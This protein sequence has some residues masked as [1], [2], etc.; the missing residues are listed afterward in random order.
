MDLNNN[1]QEVYQQPWKDPDRNQF[2]VIRSIIQ[3]AEKILV[4][5]KNSFLTD[6][7]PTQSI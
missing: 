4:S 2:Q 5:L 6:Y 3:R 7:T 1:P